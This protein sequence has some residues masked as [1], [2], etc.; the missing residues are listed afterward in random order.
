MLNSKFIISVAAVA[1]MSAGFWLSSMQQSSDEKSAQQQKQ[2]ELAEARENYS[3][4]QG[5]VSSPV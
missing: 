1:A 2:K 4:I 5:T 3:P